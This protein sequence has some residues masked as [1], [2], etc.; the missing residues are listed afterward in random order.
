MRILKSA[1][2][3]QLYRSSH[4]NFKFCF[5]LL[6]I[7]E[8]SKSGENKLT[9]HQL[10]FCDLKEQLAELQAKFSQLN[11]EIKKKH[12]ALLKGKEE[13]DKLR[14]QILLPDSQDNYS[15]LPYRPYRL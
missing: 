8:I 6:F 13:R 15:K 9:K 12:Q 2:C 5:V 14:Y 7:S 4:N 3:A 11:E 1:L 10:R